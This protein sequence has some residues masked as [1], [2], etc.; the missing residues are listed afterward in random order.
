MR[1]YAY[2]AL[3]PTLN[4]H[5]V[6]RQLIL[7]HRYRNDLVAIERKRLEER[8]TVIQPH[9]T[10]RAVEYARLK[11]SGVEHPK[12]PKFKLP[13]EDQAKVDAIDEASYL[14]TKV[15][16]QT[17]ED[18]WG[19]VLAWGTYLRVD[20]DVR[21]VC[22]SIVL[23]ARLDLY[24]CFAKQIAK[25]PRVFLEKMDLRD[26]AEVDDDAS[27][28]AVRGRRFKACLSDFRDVVEDAVGRAGGVYAQLPAA[29][30]TQT[31]AKC[32]AREEFDAARELRHMCSKCGAEWDQDENACEN[33]LRAAKQWTPPP[34][35]LAGENGGKF[36]RLTAAQRRAKGLE[37]R[38]AKSRS[39]KVS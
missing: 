16:R 3:A 4:A 12:L 23:D 13:D 33:L 34:A 35:P 36:K 19:D 22:E 17:M 14:A 15:C 7:A 29:W 8:D 18:R 27:V 25:Y 20:E 26:F 32:E 2:G 37:T 6:E 5:L 28:Q 1:T 39:K 21:R 10:A 11:E 9:V 24:R 38:R 31:C 30:T